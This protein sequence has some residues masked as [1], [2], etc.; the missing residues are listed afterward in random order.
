MPSEVSLVCVPPEFLSK[1]QA[2]AWPA[3]VRSA[4]LAREGALRAARI[5]TGRRILGRKQVLRTSPFDSPTK[6][7]WTSTTAVTTRRRGRPVV[8]TR[9]ARVRRE[10]LGKLAAFYAAYESARLRYISGDH[11]ALFPPGTYRFRLLGARLS[12]IP[13]AA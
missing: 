1:E 5:A 7:R 2:L 4:V 6:N 8:A 3:K 12:A 10:R 11:T 9:D 13:L